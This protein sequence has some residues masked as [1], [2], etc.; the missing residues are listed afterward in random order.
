MKLNEGDLVYKVNH[1]V[2]VTVSQV[3]ETFHSEEETW[4][5]QAGHIGVAAAISSTDKG[6]AA[7]LNCFMI[8]TIFLFLDLLADKPLFHIP[9]CVLSRLP[10]AYFCAF[11]SVTGEALPVNAFICGAGLSP[12][13][14]GPDPKHILNQQKSFQ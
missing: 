8:N 13:L 5:P 4:A 9:I 2:G 10:S 7:F 11:W 12:A 1:C 3:L 6:E 14:A